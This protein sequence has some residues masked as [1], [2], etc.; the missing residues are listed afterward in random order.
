MIT[1]FLYLRQSDLEFLSRLQ[2]CSYGLRCLSWMLQWFYN[3]ALILLFRPNDIT[4]VP[5]IS[6]H[7]RQRPGRKSQF[8]KLKWCK[9]I[10]HWGVCS[11]LRS[12]SCCVTLFDLKKHASISSKKKKTTTKKPPLLKWVSLSTVRDVRKSDRTVVWALTV[13]WDANRSI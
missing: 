11:A 1:V 9:D 6:I 5:I 2:S 3:I 10:F 7:R 12:S 8:V 13:C 4:L